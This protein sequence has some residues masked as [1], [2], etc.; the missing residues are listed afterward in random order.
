[1]TAVN[2]SDFANFQFSS[3]VGF[4]ELAYA[5]FFHIRYYSLNRS[6]EMALF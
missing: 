1:M 3:A 5:S 2:F 4:I 6:D